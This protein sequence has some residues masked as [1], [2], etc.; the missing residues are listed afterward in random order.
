MPEAIDSRFK[1]NHLSCKT[2]D[3]DRVMKILY[4]YQYF[5]TP[6]GSWSTRAYELSRRWVQK[7]HEVTVV[8]SPYDKS[9]IKA[10][11]YLERRE[12]E[13]IR[14]I[15]IDSGDSN[16]LPIWKRVFNAVRFAIT[17]AYYAIAVESDVVIASSGP[18][19]VGIPGILARWLGGRTLVFEVRDLWP[20]G[21]IELGLIRGWVNK[22]LCY[23]FEALCY[24][25]SRLVVTASIGMEQSVKA[26]FP[27]TRTLVIPNA[28]D[29]GLFARKP[30]KSKTPD[31]LPWS[32]LDPDEKLFLYTGSLGLMDA[33]DEVLRGFWRLKGKVPFRCLILGDGAE[34]RGLEKLSE[35]LGLSEHVKFLGLR[36]KYE[37]AEYYSLATASFVVFKDHPVHGTVSPNKMF[38][39]LAAGV[40]IVQN[41]GGWIRDLIDEHGCG[42]NVKAGDP[43]SMAEAIKGCYDVVAMMAKAEACEKLAR[44][45]FDRDRLA[46]IYLQN[47]TELEEK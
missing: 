19:T 20:Q 24:R 22:R 35:E 23:L 3:P 2:N 10:S 38:D 5:G 11:K 16:R 27:K 18:I 31:S 28:S 8:T 32:S 39:S 34:R 26:R 41:T 4:V 21:G 46:G 9:D 33:V 36:P 47:L 1:K 14:L 37:I 7:G 6:G 12:L 43:E 44:G 15:V 13:G 17:A 40:P 45:M 25:N 29:N 30:G 42:F